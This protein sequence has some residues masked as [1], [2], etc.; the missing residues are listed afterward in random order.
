MGSED[1]AMNTPYRIGT[2]GWNYAHWR[3]RFYPEKLPGSKWLAHYATH[4]DTVECNATFYRLPS[5]KTFRTWKASTPEGFLWALKAS[6]LVTHYRRLRDVREPLEQFLCHARL[7]GDKLGPV[8]FQLPPSLHYDEALFEDFASL[9]APFGQVAVEVRHR[10]WIDDR[11]F[12]QLQTHA[13][14]FCI[15]DTAGRYPFHEA[16]TAD[17]VYIR[18]HGSRKLYASNYSESEIQCWAEK[19]VSWNRPTYVYFDNDFEGYAVFNALRLKECLGI[20]PPSN[21][22]A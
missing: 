3:G 20:G 9:L 10:S 4:F 8:L 22:S 14:A 12:Q 5:E 19:I 21:H 11:F 2:S 13:L 17:F 6:R 1:S 18:L 15:A 7:L 16:V